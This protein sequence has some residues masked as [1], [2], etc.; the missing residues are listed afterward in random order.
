MRDLPFYLFDDMGDGASFIF[1]LDE[2]DTSYAYPPA[3]DYFNREENE[4]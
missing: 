2:R 4:N 3:V 1:Q